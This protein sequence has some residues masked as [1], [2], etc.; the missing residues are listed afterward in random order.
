[1]KKGRSEYAH[2]A[3]RQRRRAPRSAHRASSPLCSRQ[4]YAAKI[5]MAC[6]F[7]RGIF[8]F[9]LTRISLFLARTRDLVGTPSPSGTSARHCCL[10]RAPA[11]HY[12]ESAP[13]MRDTASGPRGVAGAD[14][15]RAFSPRLLPLAACPP[16]RVQGLGPEPW[17]RLRELISSGGCRVLVC[18]RGRLT[19]CVLCFLRFPARAPQ[20]LV[21]THSHV[22]RHPNQAAA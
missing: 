22:H 17:A 4:R 1:M 20:A 3:L 16:P 7:L 10:H 18:S 15:A 13:C 9:F 5:E 8:C 11:P 12:A 14:I 19:R 21:L 6:I 2:G